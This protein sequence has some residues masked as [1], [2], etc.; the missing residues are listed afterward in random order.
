MVLGLVLAII[1]TIGVYCGIKVSWKWSDFCRF[2]CNVDERLILSLLDC[3]LPTGTAVRPQTIRETN[4]SHGSVIVQL[5]KPARVRQG[6]SLIT[7]TTVEANHTLGL[8][9]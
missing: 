2:R 6:A 4:C 9:N 3:E 1:L 8:W 5:V 7:A